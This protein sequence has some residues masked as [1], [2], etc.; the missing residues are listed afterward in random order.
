MPRSTSRSW[1]EAL[2]RFESP[3]QPDDVIPKDAFSTD[4]D[5]ATEIS[6]PAFKF[7]EAE[8]DEAP[9]VVAP[10]PPAAIEHV[11][12]PAADSG[13]ATITSPPVAPLDR[14]RL[15]FS[16]RRRRVIAAA[17]GAVA[18]LVV[19]AIALGGGTPDPKLSVAPAVD[20]S[21]AVV[22]AP[23]AA[24]VVETTPIDAAIAE[25]APADA[26]IESEPDAG[27][28]RHVV[29]P[30]HP[31]PHHIVVAAPP[32]PPSPTAQ[33]LFQKAFQAFVHGDTNEALT[34][35]KAAKTTNPSYAPTWRLLGQVYKKLGDHVQARAAFT[36]YLALAPTASDTAAVRKELEP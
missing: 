33:E 20:A 30:H 9:A 1:R 24:I 4:L 21:V 12:A 29:E 23:D 25:I 35:L 2:P 19:L 18:L 17:L 26:A 7:G 16:T 28:A 36:R 6:A 27:I 11:D 15:F 22:A 32:R 31:E 34:D 3:I 5:N 10:P 8:I 14:L 13:D